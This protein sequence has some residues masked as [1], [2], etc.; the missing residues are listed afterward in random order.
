MYTDK[1]LVEQVL[2]GNTAA[3]EELM[4]RYQQPVFTIIYRMI[5]KYQ[6]SEDIAQDV[7][8][9]VY[10]KLY[11]F[12]QTKNFS[13]WLY[14]IAVNTC[15]TAMRK[16]KK[17]V[18]ISLHED[19]SEQIEPNYDYSKFDPQTILEQKELRE[20]IKSSIE[21][22]PENYKI[23]IVLRYDMGLTNQEIADILH[24]TKDNVEVKIHRA[25]KALR[26]IIMETGI[27]GG[28]SHELPTNRSNSASSAEK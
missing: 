26:K 7:F 5:G 11:Q 9:T 10:Q 25:R 12:D 8:L 1:Q 22:L 27:K 23:V 19:F 3:F 24:I 17:V 2:G 28:M 4:K 13:P 15:I 16:K 14:R 20:V 18:N 21:K 6:D